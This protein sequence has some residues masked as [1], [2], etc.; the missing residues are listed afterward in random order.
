VICQSGIVEINQVEREV[1]E[2]ELPDLDRIVDTYFQIKSLDSKQYFNQLRS[3][4]IPE[5]RR[6]FEQRKIIWFSFLFHDYKNFPDR[7]PSIPGIY[8]V[9]IKLCP[10]KNVTMEDLKQSLPQHFTDPI[11]YPCSKLDGV[12]CLD[13]L[14]DQNWAYAWKHFGETSEWVLNLI[15]THDPETEIP[16][17]HVIQFLHFA[18]NPLLIGCKSIFLPQEKEWRF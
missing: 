17:Q 10:S 14:K 16:L 9:H 8:Y 7:V 13:T 5:I 15:E 18:T 12:E 4:L 3:E 1:S 2:V 11:L 6:L